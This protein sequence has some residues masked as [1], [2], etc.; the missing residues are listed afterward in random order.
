MKYAKQLKEVKVR[1]TKEMI[2]PKTLVQ[3]KI[4]FFLLGVIQNCYYFIILVS[5]ND[6]EAI[7]KSKSAVLVSLG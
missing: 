5:L 1:F 7:F 6:M 3:I 4:I 2:P